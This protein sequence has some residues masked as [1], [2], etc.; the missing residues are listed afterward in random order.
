M[1][2]DFL[3]RLTAPAPDA[4]SDTDARLAL[5]ALLVRIAKSDGDY[6]SD[7]AA[8]IERIAAARYD[9]SP[10]EATALRKEAAILESE[11]PDTVRFTRAIKEAVPLEA[12]IQ[13]IEA[14]W[15]VVLVDG[16]RDA[17]ED[18]IL[19]LAANLLGVSDRDSAMARQRMTKHT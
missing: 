12:R 18:S 1:F 10:F 8:R 3:K 6:S 15:Q 14:M 19:R 11:A 5:C 13:V 16:E 2:A 7:E 17:R 9:L 4:L